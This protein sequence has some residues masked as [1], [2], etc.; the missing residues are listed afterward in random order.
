[1][2]L[3][4]WVSSVRGSM[5]SRHTHNPPAFPS[6]LLSA[7]LRPSLH[8]SRP[9]PPPAGKQRKWEMVE[10]HP[11]VAILLYHIELWLQQP[12]LHCTSPRP[13]VGKQRK[14]EMVESHPS[15][16]ILLYHTE[17]R[18]VIIVRQFRP[19]VGTCNCC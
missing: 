7:L 6:R 5:C 8:P 19:A 10:S 16:A 1:M 2:L 12:T 4:F 15:V 13:P 9:L 11:S 18:A 14:W 3:M 17:R